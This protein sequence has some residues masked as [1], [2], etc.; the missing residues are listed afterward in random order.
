MSYQYYTITSL[1]LSTETSVGP[2]RFMPGQEQDV[3]ITDYTA[4]LTDFTFYVNSGRLCSRAPRMIMSDF[5]K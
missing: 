1:S 5:I 3:G 4:L 2:Y